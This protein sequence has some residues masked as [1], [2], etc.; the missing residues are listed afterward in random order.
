M[1]RIDLV[2][3]FKLNEE[4]R[5]FAVGDVHGYLRV[6]DKLLEEVGFDKTKDRLFSVGDLVDRGPH[7]IQFSD[8]IF[9]PW[10][11]AVRGNHECIVLQHHD[12]QYRIQ[13]GSLWFV[14]EWED[15]Q[16]EI[17]LLL[18]QLPV[19]IDIQTK[20]GLVGIVHANVPGD[21][22]GLF[23][24]ALVDWREEIVNYAT[25]D[26]SRWRYRDR[27]S[28]PVKGAS[29]VIVGHCAH[30]EVR[31]SHNVVDIDTGC[32]YEGGKLTLWSIDDMKVAAE[33]TYEYNPITEPTKTGW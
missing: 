9:Q 25:W 31:I 21:D 23:T 15:S 24:R 18:G 8:Y 28:P 19:A 3:H 10:M 33:S 30:D 6:L 13:N 20:H 4:G 5:D 16:Q 1:V 29:L 14:N 32:G 7:S 22:W 17:K 27:E 11:H 2:K 12:A 26:R